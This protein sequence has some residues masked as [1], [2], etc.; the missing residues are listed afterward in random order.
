MCILDI[1]FNITVIVVYLTIFS[2]NG[3][4]SFCDFV[5]S[6]VGALSILKLILLLVNDQLCMEEANSIV[7][8]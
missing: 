5:K 2:D 8:R 1:I 7:M 4:L 6:S 3:I